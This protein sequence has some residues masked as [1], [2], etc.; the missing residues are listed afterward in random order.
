[1]L[2]LKGK[3]VS[4]GIA[5]GQLAI[6]NHCLN[7]IPHYIIAD[8]EKEIQRFQKAQQ[9]ALE[10]FQQLYAAA[11]KEVSEENANIFAVHQMMLEDCD[12]VEEI[13]RVIRLEKV[14]AEFAIN[15]TAKKF[16]KVFTDMEDEYMRARAS[17]IHDISNNLLAFLAG[18]TKTKL[19]F[20]SP[21][22]LAATDLT[23]SET[24]HLA[25]G[26][27]LG[28]ITEH[29][30]ANSHSAIL[31][32]ALGIPAVIGVRKLLSKISANMTVVIDGFTGD[33]Y[34]NPDEKTLANM[35]NKI[36]TLKYHQTLLKELKGQPNITMSGKEIKLAANISGPQDL[37]AVLENDADGIGLFR[38]EFLYLENK[39]IPTE[40]EQ[41]TAYKTVIETMAGKQVIIRTLD[42]GADKN[43]PYL[44]LFPENNPAMGCRGIRFCL[45]QPEIFKIQLH[46]I[47]RASAFGNTAIMLPLITSIHEIHAAKIILEEVKVSLR[48]N[49]IPFDENI[50]VGIMIETP[51][52]AL[53]SEDLAKEVDFFS[54]GTND[55]T[56]YTLAIDRQNQNLSSFFNP[57][58]K[59]IFK[60]IAQTIESAHKNGI[61]VGICGE[62]GADT[63]LT[64]MFL[65]L[66]ADEL[67][68]SPP[69]I[70]PLRKKIRSLE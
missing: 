54:I 32:R 27:I 57:Q 45:M 63:N 21:S 10:N 34:L 15:I 12:Y 56:Q 11:L 47:L 60:L 36:E 19:S 18:K 55:L 64:K 31:A 40:D 58:H 48:Q 33:I 49:N 51:A 41:F 9:A 3:G 68:V 5:I 50:K 65:E 39:K 4:D 37:A 29:G 2:L 14:N 61:W 52:A 23:P 59:A 13:E 69:A 66:G 8:P 7:S 67:S 44:K 35:T 20:N 38:S 1:M 28:F 6:Y 43:I 53:I 62:L 22:V 25:K 30:S 26:K 70:L 42:V 24:M 46:A 17:D 16:A